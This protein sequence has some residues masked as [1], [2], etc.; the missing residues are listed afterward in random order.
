[1]KDASSGESLPGA[2]V[3]LLELKKGV[4]A[5]N[6]GFYSIS[7]PKGNYQVKVSYLG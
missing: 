1:M 4:N 5:N 7:V 6:Y 2:T 3:G